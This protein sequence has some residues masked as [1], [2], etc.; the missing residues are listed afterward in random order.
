[1]Y[2]Y[3]AVWWTPVCYI[4]GNMK[5]CLAALH[6]CAC[7]FQCVAL[8][9]GTC[10]QHACFYMP[11]WPVPDI[12]HW[13]TYIHIHLVYMLASPVYIYKC[14][15]V[16]VWRCAYMG[17]CMMHSTPC[18]HHIRTLYILYNMTR[19]LSCNSLP[20]CG[21]YDLP[22][23]VVCTRYRPNLKHGQLVCICHIF[24]IEW[25]GP[26]WRVLKSIPN[27]TQRLSLLLKSTTLSCCSRRCHGGKEAICMFH[28]IITTL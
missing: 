2:T 23:S 13:H 4:H 17:S 14:V 15:H 12:L 11:V 21:H 8:A 7:S 25:S 9:F 5:R 26:I 1:M 24:K 20:I 27:Q 18:D 22:A 6:S 10:T 19:N 16:C 3:V 28:Y